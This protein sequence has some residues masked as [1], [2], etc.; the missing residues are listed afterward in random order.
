MR[1]SIKTKTYPFSFREALIIDHKVRFKK[2]K[3]QI[4]Y[5]FSKQ[6]AINYFIQ[7]NYSFLG[8]YQI[9]NYPD[10]KDHYRIIGCDTLDLFFC[11]IDFICKEGIH[12]EK[13]LLLKIKEFL[14]L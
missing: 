6:D 8:N 9:D 5:A 11:Q 10:F 14:H 3:W 12:E 13:R 4:I 7:K 1:K 2:K